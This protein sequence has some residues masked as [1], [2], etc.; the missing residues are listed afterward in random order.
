MKNTIYNSLITSLLLLFTVTSCHKKNTSFNYTQAVET[1]GGY[2]EAQQMT[3]LLLNT[4]F[5]S[6]TDSTLLADG[7]S[8]IDGAIVTYNSSPAKIIIHYP[9]SKPDGYS[10]FRRGIIEATSETGF[11]NTGDV[12]KLSFESFYYDN[13]SISTENITIING[14]ENTNNTFNISSSNIYRGSKDTLGKPTT[15]I[16]FQLQQKLT[17]FKDAL[18]PYHT[19]NDYFGITGDLT[20]VARNKFSFKASI[21]DTNMLINAYNCNWIKS[22]ITNI[23]LPEFTYNS[24]ANFTLDG[25]CVNI[26]SVITNDSRITAAFDIKH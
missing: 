13:D 18:S 21:T 5:K 14:L 10:H 23:E 1:V 26:Y 2:V 15:H 11:F 8:E 9:F 6:I 12:I 19:Q 4:Y 22:G 7:T 3:D 20:G 24:L 25:E 16:K 17:Q